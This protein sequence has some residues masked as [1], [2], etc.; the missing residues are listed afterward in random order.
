MSYRF[1]NYVA[2]P[3]HRYFISLVVASR[4]VM[5]TA[6][7]Y[8]SCNVS[9]RELQFHYTRQSPRGTRVHVESHSTSLTVRIND[10]LAVLYR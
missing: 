1:E 3:Q 2:L 5:L 7:D 10:L 8:W 4:Y 6:I 9:S